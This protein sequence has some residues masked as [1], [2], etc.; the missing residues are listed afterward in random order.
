VEISGNV[1]SAH[2]LYDYIEV[3]GIK[4]ATKR[5]VFLRKEDNTPLTPDPVLV[6]LSLSE[7][8]LA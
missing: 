6:S 8:R 1:A 3:Q 5:Q 7:I 4:I 2:Y